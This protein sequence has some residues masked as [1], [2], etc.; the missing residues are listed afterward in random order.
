MSK[1][2]IVIRA[3]TLRRDA[4]AALLL[5]RQLEQR[6]CVVIVASSRDFVRT[7]RFWKPDVAVINT[8]GQIR[9]CAELSPDAAI[10]FLPG[11]GANAKKHS[12]ATLL[13]ADPAAFGIADKFLLWGEATERFFWE[14]LPK[15]DREKIVVCGNPRLD[16]AKFN[17]DLLNIPAEAKTI[18][19]I[20]RYHTLN[21]YNAVPAIFS[22]Q[23]PEKRNGVMWQVENFF[24]SITIIRRLI[25]ETDFRISI[26]PHPLEAPEGYSFMKEGFF[27]GRVEIDGSLDLAAWTARQRVIVAPSSQSFYEAYV[28][29]VPVVNI[30]PLTGN[31]DRIRGITPNA[32]LS[33]E[34]SYNPG[35][36]DEA[37]QLIR[38]GLRAPIRNHDI[39]R[40]LAEFHDWNSPNSA[41]ARAAEAIMEVAEK[42]K[43]AAGTRAPTM[44]MDLWDRASFRRAHWRD[45]LHANFSY[46][47]HYHPAPAYFRTILENIRDGRSI[48]SVPAAMLA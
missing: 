23:S 29:G 14:S 15:A 5:A 27:A 37:V 47:R 4:A 31:A 28:L 20:G 46:H 12:D 6:G 13:A 40:H 8:V 18:G 34:V 10:V 33:Q 42:K 32:A 36:Y 41:T 17:F 24:C 1:P 39:D 35:S 43:T 45:P 22:M 30:D 9:R 19:F 38:Q 21:R 3:F 16:L 2:R 11:E 48:I 7:M 25:E 26:R 44:A